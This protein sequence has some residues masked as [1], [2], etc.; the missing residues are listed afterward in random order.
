MTFS[1]ARVLAL[2]LGGRR[3]GLAASDLMG[4]T[5]QGLPT[6]V[7]RN[8]EQDFAALMRLAEE[9]QITLFLLGLPLHLSGEEGVQAQKARAFGT[10]LAARSRIPVQYWDERLTTAAAQ[11]VLRSAGASLGQR[12]KAVDRMAAVI[13]LQSFLD[14]Q[15]R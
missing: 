9:R 6:L 15:Y 1:G 8:R 12:Q 3:I 10:K 14:A 4:I 2:D 11:R 13:L 5:A 7:R